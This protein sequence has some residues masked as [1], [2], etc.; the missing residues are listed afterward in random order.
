MAG[1]CYADNRPSTEEKVES[2]QENL[3]TLQIADYQYDRVA[4]LSDGRVK[5]DG[6]YI[7]FTEDKTE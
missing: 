1:L 4:A 7:G 6:C 5:V 3:L 2:S